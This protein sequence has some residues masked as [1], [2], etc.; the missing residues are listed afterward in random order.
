MEG[1]E[2]K[3]FQISATFQLK[4]C[5]GPKSTYSTIKKSL[6]VIKIGNSLFSGSFHSHHS[7]KIKSV[8]SVIVA[9]GA[10]GKTDVVQKDV[11]GDLSYRNSLKYHE[12]YKKLDKNILTNFNH[13]KAKALSISPVSLS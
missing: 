13:F 4:I 3:G 5:Q 2:N 9:L 10:N 8:W 11:M 12:V 7:L 1:P 6:V